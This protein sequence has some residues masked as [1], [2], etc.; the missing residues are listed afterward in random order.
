[1]TAAEPMTAFEKE[2]AYA[3]IAAGLEKARRRGDRR[4]VREWSA[5]RRKIDS[6]PTMAEEKPW[7]ATR[8]ARRTQRLLGVTGRQI[9]RYCA[10]TNPVHPSVAVIVHLLLALNGTGTPPDRVAAWYLPA[11][12]D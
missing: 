6:A 2:L 11:R 5:L 7:P 4:A 1:M 12:T 10:G 8:T 3:A 9:Q